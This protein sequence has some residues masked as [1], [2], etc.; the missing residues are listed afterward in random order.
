M[1]RAAGPRPETGYS[2]TDSGRNGRLTLASV[3]ES[4]SLKWV[5]SGTS[6]SIG[7]AHL[8]PSDKRLWNDHNL[9]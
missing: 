9:E 5:E 2:E 7:P 1:G 4:A 6:P 3:P 8:P